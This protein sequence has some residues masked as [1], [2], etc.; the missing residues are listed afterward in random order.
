V[1]FTL[2][3]EDNSKEYVVH[4]GDINWGSVD[5]SDGWCLGGIQAN[6]N[7]NS[8]DWLLGDAFLRNV[9]V[10]HHGATSTQPPLIGLLNMTDPTIAMAEF[11]RERGSDPSPPPASQNLVTHTH[12]ILKLTIISILSSLVGW[13]TGVVAVTTI[14]RS[15]RASKKR[16]IEL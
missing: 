1:G 2:G 9:H 8:A 5:S 10:A 6:D 15:R 11:V 14:L 4:P 3:D 16:G 7:V 13:V 12:P